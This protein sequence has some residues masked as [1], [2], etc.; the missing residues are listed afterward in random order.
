MLKRSEEWR[1]IIDTEAAIDHNLT[2]S[3]TNQSSRYDAFKGTNLK[4]GLLDLGMDTI[5]VCG[6]P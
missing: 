4:E 3:L 1:L 5:V 6:T 2:I